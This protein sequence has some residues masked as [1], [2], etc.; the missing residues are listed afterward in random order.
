MFLETSMRGVFQTAHAQDRKPVLNP[1]QRL[2][3]TMRQQ[4]VVA[5]RDPLAK[6]MDTDQH[7]KKADE[8]EK[9]RK[10][11][12]QRQQVNPHDRDHIDPINGVGLG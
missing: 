2:E 3:T 11:C 5:D 8:T 6:A 4:L 7:R 10:E 1:R 9:H 12:Q